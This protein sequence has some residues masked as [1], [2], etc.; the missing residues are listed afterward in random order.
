MQTEEQLGNSPVK[1]QLL[2]KTRS[3]GKRGA[4]LKTGFGGTHLNGNTVA[5]FLPLGSELGMRTSR[6]PRALCPQLADAHSDLPLRSCSG[7]DLAQHHLLS[8]AIIAPPIRHPNLCHFI[9]NSPLYLAI[10]SAHR[11]LQKKCLLFA[12]SW[13]YFPSCA[14]TQS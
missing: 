11:L 1:Q 8:P 5:R 9:P 2:L 4:K 10:K 6:C 13:Q 3:T 7:S 14:S 12:M